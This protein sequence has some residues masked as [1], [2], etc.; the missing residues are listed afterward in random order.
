M[1][2]AEERDRVGSVLDGWTLERVIGRG[3]MGVVYAASDSSGARAAVKILHAAFSRNPEVQERFRREAYAANRV[4]H[5]GAV[6][7]LADGVIGTDEDHERASYL[8]MELLEGESL[9]HRLHTD[10]VPSSLE[11]LAILDGVL[12]VLDNAH[13]RG[14]L[15][16][17]LKPA[18]LFLTASGDPLVKVLDFGLARIE[19]L[20]GSTGAGH[21][22]G[23]PSYMAP[24]LASGRGADVDA[25][26][27]L[28]ALGATAFVVLTGKPVHEAPTPVHLVLKM[29]S[30]SAPSVKSC[31][32]HASSSVARIVDRALSFRKED[33]YPSAAAMRDDVA[34]AIELGI[35]RP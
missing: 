16:R 23:T 18:N 35:T 26:T 29:A 1:S 22:L 15:H 17:D 19:E 3:G 9:E 13:R 12:D 33:R 8:V 14:V 6:R 20:Q 27:D 2:V 4:E 7:M 25:R 34:A 11:L 21:A 32:P 5:R 10:R 24:E 31:A 28:F 30:T